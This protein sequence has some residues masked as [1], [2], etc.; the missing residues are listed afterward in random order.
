MTASFMPPV[1]SKVVARRGLTF[2]S[3][4]SRDADQRY[5]QPLTAVANPPRKR[6]GA[7][8]DVELKQRLGA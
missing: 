7:M 3:F 2:R 1:E 5:S 8:D 4:L 6:F